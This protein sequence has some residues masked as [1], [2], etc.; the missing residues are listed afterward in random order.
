MLQTAQAFY[1]YVISLFQIDFYFFILHLPLKDEGSWRALLASLAGPQNTT[2]VT[3]VTAEQH[4][5]LAILWAL[6]ISS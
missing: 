1:F 3:G 6:V 2:T 4:L 5:I